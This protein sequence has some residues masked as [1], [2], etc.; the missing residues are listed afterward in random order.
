MNESSSCRILDEEPLG[1]SG[2][3][4]LVALTRHSK[5]SAGL[6]SRFLLQDAS[7]HLTHSS[8]GNKSAT[9]SFPRELV[10]YK[11]NYHKLYKRLVGRIKKYF[12]SKINHVRK[13]QLE[14]FSGS[15]KSNKDSSC[16]HFFWRFPPPIILRRSLLNLRKWP[17][18]W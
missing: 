8:L 11:Y 13:V 4:L 1:Q 5:P 16:F 10:R 18:N 14:Y 7:I 2:S 9:H 15:K 12:T 6:A 3:G 17:L